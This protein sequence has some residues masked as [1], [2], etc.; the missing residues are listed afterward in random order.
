MPKGF[1][2][3][4]DIGVSTLADVW[5][6]NG[7]VPFGNLQAEYHMSEAQWL[8]YRQLRQE[9]QGRIPWEEDT[10]EDSP[11]ENRCSVGGLIDG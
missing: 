3:W 6:A 8:K 4:D 11:L 5:D 10:Q 9:L 2:R 7:V 1:Q